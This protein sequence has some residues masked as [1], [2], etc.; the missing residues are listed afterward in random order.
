MSILMQPGLVQSGD[1]ASPSC[2]AEANDETAPA[3]SYYPIIRDPHDLIA[4]AA[5]RLFE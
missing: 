1:A 2:A 3:L 4:L 5:S